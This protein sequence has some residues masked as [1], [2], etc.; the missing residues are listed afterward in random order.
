MFADSKSIDKYFADRKILQSEMLEL[1]MDKTF[2]LTESYKEGTKLSIDLSNSKLLYKLKFKVSH[3]SI[4]N[5]KVISMPNMVLIT[6]SN[7]YIIKLWSLL[8]KNLWILNLEY[9]LP[10]KWDLLINRF[11]QRKAK[12]L[13]A[14]KIKKEIDTKWYRARN[15]IIEAKSPG[16]KAFNNQSKCLN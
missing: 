3:E 2:H 6:C 8:G 4:T 16:S 10:Y 15:S 14:I 9:P 1:K 12:Y 13:A 5:A 11:H 7:S